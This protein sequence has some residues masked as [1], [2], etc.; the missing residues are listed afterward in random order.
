MNMD[1][2]LYLVAVLVGI[3]IGAC[4]VGII[5]GRQDRKDR[6][7]ERM[8]HYTV[9]NMLDKLAVE[10]YDL[11]MRHEKIFTA[12]TSNELTPFDKEFIRRC[13]I[14]YTAMAEEAKGR[15]EIE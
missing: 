7:L 9:T 1:I 11:K 13:Q 8:Q 15:E 3:M 5:N 6:E 12:N 10:I 14:T 2:R 4:V